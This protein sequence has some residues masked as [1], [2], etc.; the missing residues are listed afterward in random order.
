MRVCYFGTYRAGYSRNK[1]MIKGLKANKCQVQECHVPLWRGIEDRVQAASGNWWKPSF[2][3]RIVSC[4]VALLKKYRSI[5]DYDVMVVGYP[6]H[7]D[8][9][10]ARLLTWFNNKPLAWD[11]LMSAYLLSVERGLDQ[12]G[13]LTVKALKYIERHAL[14]LPGLLF[15]DTQRHQEWFMSTHKMGR[16]RFQLIPIGADDDV[17]KPLKPR[18]DK[19]QL[20]VVYFG[21]YIPNHGL[22]YML[23]ACRQL[24]D[25]NSVQFEF[26]GTGPESGPS[27]KLAEQ[28]NLKNITF[29]D[30]MDQDALMDKVSRADILLGAFGQTRM[31]LMTIQNKIYEG[32]ALAM[33]V[34][35]G[36]SP[37]VRD[38][39]DHGKNIYLCDRS[40]PKDLA[41]AILTLKQDPKLLDSL[42]RNGHEL[43]LK[44]FSISKIGEAFKNHLKELSGF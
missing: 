3:I 43:Y 6:G 11:V 29:T 18:P 7:F 39:F 20:K 34:V 1:I 22:D 33:P 36:D 25:Y 21:T 16:Q 35:T 10:L 44:S 37:A 19:G 24:K 12:K 15:I 9:F 40:N 41:K 2:L 26:I 31:S 32:L 4:Y 42:A 17:F 5:K 27:R 13:P 28:F 14:R 30:W 38:C 23:E 8:V